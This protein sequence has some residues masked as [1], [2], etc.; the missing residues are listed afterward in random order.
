MSQVLDAA[1]CADVVLCVLGPTAS[2]EDSQH[3]AAGRRYYLF[4]LSNI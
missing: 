1:K 4:Q 2:L 3:T